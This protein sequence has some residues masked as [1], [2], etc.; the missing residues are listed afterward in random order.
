M[1]WRC[2]VVKSKHFISASV[3]QERWLAFMYLLWKDLQSDDASFNQ[4]FTSR[5]SLREES[6]WII[7]VH[8][9]YNTW[10]QTPKFTTKSDHH[11]TDLIWSD[12]RLWMFLE[13]SASVKRRRKRKD[14]RRNCADESRS[15]RREKRRKAR[16]RWRNSRRKNRRSFTWRS[17]Q[18]RENCCWR[19]GTSSP[20]G[21]SPSYWAEQRFQKA[22]FM[23]VCICDV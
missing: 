19:R 23:N 13:N 17:P 11:C 14:E 4:T 22:L 7:S 21:S 20:S 8:Q 6:H 12:E 1:I 10:W 15:W 16:R 5:F 2:L 18:K 3:L 9:H